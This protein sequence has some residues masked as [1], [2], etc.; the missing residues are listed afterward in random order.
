M[1]LMY[2]IVLVWR[3]PVIKKK[4]KKDLNM[5]SNILL[6]LNNSFAMRC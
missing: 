6:Y 4:K 3:C 1:P 5:I 2:F